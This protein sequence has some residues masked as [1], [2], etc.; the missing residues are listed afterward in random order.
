MD[1][2][3]CPHDSFESGI[4]GYKAGYFLIPVAFL[5]YSNR[6]FDSGDS[7]CFIFVPLSGFHVIAEW[8]ILQFR[9]GRTAISR[10]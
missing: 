6:C 7:L 1:L 9:K 4:G 10:S 3:V 8:P 2:Q 5:N